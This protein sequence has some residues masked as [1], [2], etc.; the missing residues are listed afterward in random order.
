MSAIERL[1]FAAGGPV[2]YRTLLGLSFRSRREFNVWLGGIALVVIPL[3]LSMFY[4][5]AL[6]FAVFALGWD[7]YIRGESLGGEARYQRLLFRWE[8]RQERRHPVVYSPMRPE[9]GIVVG[10]QPVATVP[11]VEFGRT[12]RFPVEFSDGSTEA[13]VVYLENLDALCLVIEVDGVG[14]FLLDPED[15]ESARSEVSKWVG[16]LGEV[17][18]RV[19]CYTLQ[20]DANMSDYVEDSEVL[21]EGEPVTSL[22]SSVSGLADVFAD[23]AQDSPSFL[24]LIATL[25]SRFIKRI[26]AQRQP[27]DTSSLM[28]GARILAEEVE[29]NVIER[30][31]DLGHSLVRVLDEPKLAAVVAAILDTTVDIFDTRGMTLD[32]VFPT[33]VNED[34]CVDLSSGYGRTVSRTYHWLS[35]SLQDH[36]L[37]SMESLLAPRDSDGAPLWSMTSFIFDRIPPELV[38]PTFRAKAGVARRAAKARG[39]R[40]GDDDIE[41]RVAERGLD[42]TS[43]DGGSYAGLVMTTYTTLFA[44]NHE[45]LVHAERAFQRDRSRSEVRIEPLADRQHTKGLMNALPFG[46][47]LERA[48]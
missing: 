18:D 36:G 32:N 28:V 33:I 38:R 29:T 39:E 6:V 48:R 34:T 25:D 9:L 40:I 2:R 16:G 21:A 8:R 41:G 45:Y 1:S 4:L 44:P 20:R 22:M 17:I 37:H 30:L 42:E 15:R 14:G 27:E 47:G 12:R 23:R 7:Y 10:G 24:A 43:V 31:P 46:F 13:C 26:K 3:I 11:P 5:W 35:Y 19:G